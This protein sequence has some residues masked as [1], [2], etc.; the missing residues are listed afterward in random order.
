[1][2]VPKKMYASKQKNLE[3]LLKDPAMNHGTIKFGK[4][5]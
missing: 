3:Q 5:L 2:D 4:G 1:M